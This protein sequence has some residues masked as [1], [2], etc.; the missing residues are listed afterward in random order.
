MILLLAVLTSPAAAEFTFVHAS[1][2]SIS[3]E[4]QAGSHFEMAGLLWD[5]IS[6]LDPAP[7]F[8]VTTGDLTET[9]ADAEY[10][11]YAQ[12]LQFLRADHHELPGNQDVRAAREGKQ[13]FV[14]GVG[15]PLFG[16]WDHDGVHFIRLDS[17]IPFQPWGHIDQPQLDWLKRDVSKAGAQTP[18]VVAVHHWVGRDRRMIDNEQALLDILA[19]AN[20]RLWLIG[21]GRA[22]MSWNVNGATALMV[23]PL[24]QGSFHVIS[25]DEEAF[26]IRRHQFVG[27]A[28]PVRKPNSMELNLPESTLVDVAK[29]PLAGQAAPQWSIDAAI[30]GNRIDVTAQG[31]L[32]G[33]ASLSCRIDDRPARPMRPGSS[34][35]AAAHPAHELMPGQH[36]VIV[37]ATLADGRVYEQSAPISIPPAL[38]PGPAWSQNLGQPVQAG[39]LAGEG[40]VYAATTAGD[41][42]ALSADGVEQWRV[43]TGDAITSAPASDGRD[44]FVGCADGTVWA[45][46]GN[47]RQTRWRYVA[48]AAVFAGPAVAGGVVCVASADGSITGLDQQDGKPRWNVAS[49]AMFSTPIATDGR[50]FYLASQDGGLWCLDAIGGRI[51]WS[52]PAVSGSAAGA[53]ASAPLVQN[54]MVYFAPGNGSLVALNADSGNR[55]WASAGKRPGGTTPAMRDGRLYV[56]LGEV[57]KLTCLEAKTGAV[58]WESAL[59]ATITAAP[60]AAKQAVFVPAADGTV[61]ALDPQDGRTLWQYRLGRSHLLSPPVSLGDGLIIAAFDGQIAGFK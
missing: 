1:D 39:L 11:A 52:K 20:V 7:A 49:Q 9:G 13:S 19:G 27:N 32:P 55:T 34:N 36:E 25:V 45:V 61:Y 5:R 59:G 57:G 8:A 51:R 41:L 31:E 14:G 22:D 10:A 56:A 30:E 50:A 6:G 18:I 24:H 35:W 28:P 29:V 43:R 3:A 42:L 16:S 38:S 44:I 2:P 54:G 33:D 26:R 48:A 58:L 21:D 37:R 15:E 47:T 17:T 4:E 53:P 46:E 60:V 23:R 40:V 12:C